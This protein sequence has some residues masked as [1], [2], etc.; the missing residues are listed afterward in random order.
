MAVIGE[1]EIRLRA[2]IARLQ[3]DMDSARRV[4]GDAT[5][6]MSRA[7]DAAKMAIAGIASGIGLSQI[8]AMADS[9]AKFTAQ[10]KLATLSAREYGIAMDDVRRI[11]TVAQQDLNS[12]GV[13]YAKIANGTR[14]LGIAQKQVAAITEVVNLSLKV[15]GATANEASS[16]QLQLSQAFASGTLRGEEFNAVNEA[17]PRLMLALADGIGVPVGALKKM[18]EE[19]QITSKI[20][21]DVLPK[22]LEKVTAEA[23]QIQTIGGAFQ[24]LKN[25]LMEMV[26]VQ[27]NASGAVSALTGAIGLLANNLGL[28]A[29]TI[30]TVMA[31]KLG[32]WIGALVVDTYKQVAASMA[33]RAATIAAAE[34]EVASVG[35][36]LAL[37][38]ATQS[39]IIVAREESI[40]KLASSQASIASAQTAIAAATA[41]GTQSFALRALRLA[42]AELTVAEAARAAMVAELAMLG[43]QQA[44]VSAQV[45]AATIAQTAAQN[46]LTAATGAGGVAAGLGA[47][48]LGLLGGPIG[49]VITLL[50]LGATAWMVW[51]N[52]AKEGTDKATAA[53]DEST[54]EAIARLDKQI[55]KLN[56][57]NALL[58]AKPELKGMNQ[59]DIDIL[60]RTNAEINDARNGVGKYAKTSS[61]MRQVAEVTL[62]REYTEV[63]GRAASAHRKVTEAANGTRDTQIA[64]WY[65]KNGTQAQKLAAELDELRKKF[66]ELP[67]AMEAAVRA[68]YVDKSA[69]AGIKAEQTAYQSL[70]TTIGEKIAAGKLEISGYDQLS[71]SQ[72]L[73]IKLDAEIAAGKSKLTPQS[74]AL[75]RAGI[76][77]RAE[78]EKTI[79][80][81]KR[82]IE[83]AEEMAKIQA[84]YAERI[85]KSVE[86]AIKEADA[87]EESVRTFGMTK[88]A[89]EA[90]TLA[91]MEDELAR[92][93]G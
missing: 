39:M 26:G 87:A 90:L 2:D 83:Q 55:A 14:E 89:I 23:K 65:G 13:L 47:R 53:V 32:A 42:T 85:G 44:R 62:V 31:A 46:A 43:Q 71:E 52:K 93:R 35:A 49:A 64:D 78:Q 57:R 82:V 21:A 63:L 75:A 28:L 19:G 24:V 58:N 27:A 66:G 79:A 10:L 41:A 8:I 74:I 76:A 9:Y 3:R 38:G 59:A 18:A 50:G 4:V 20:M 86:T 17:A 70:M 56:E 36:K 92:L 40:A 68:K 33:A 69:V 61:F 51:G 48:A 22:A 81:N 11:A 84:E 6:G 15:S 54:T 67:P 37:L 30:A 5:A 91:R 80:T 1:M 72:K 12:T 45:T 77:E 16:A 60:A 34:A 29:G 25:N 73:T 88:S 7:A